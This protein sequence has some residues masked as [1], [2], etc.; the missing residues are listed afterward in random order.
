VLADG[1]N[2]DSIWEELTA[3]LALF[4]AER[5]AYAQLLPFS[6]TAISESVAQAIGSESFDV[7][8]E[9]RSAD[10]RPSTTTG[11]PRWGH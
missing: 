11:L 6:T 3:A 4:N 7:T 10:L 1:V 2:L 8:S 9:F 5:N